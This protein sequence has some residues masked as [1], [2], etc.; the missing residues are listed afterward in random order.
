MVG[1]KQRMVLV[2]KAFRHEAHQEGKE[3][4][5]AANEDSG[6]IDVIRYAF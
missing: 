6:V 5:K 3:E 4:D 1:S 2:I